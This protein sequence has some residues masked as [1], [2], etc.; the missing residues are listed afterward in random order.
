MVEG[1]ALP[2]RLIEK[3]SENVDVC[4]CVRDEV[5]EVEPVN[6]FVSEFSKDCETLRESLTSSEEDRVHESVQVG[7][8]ERDTE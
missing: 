7:V 2:E 8:D 6:V 5:S 4:D 3:S 1:D